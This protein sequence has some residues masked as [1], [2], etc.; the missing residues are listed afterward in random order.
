MK[1]L[2]L[3]KRKVS[4]QKRCNPIQNLLTFFISYSF[5]IY[6]K[7]S[8]H[9]KIDNLPLKTVLHSKFMFLQWEDNYNYLHG[10]FIL[11]SAQTKACA[12][13]MFRLAS[14]ENIGKHSFTMSS[15]PQTVFQRECYTLPVTHCPVLKAEM[16]CILR[17]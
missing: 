6:K 14:M 5:E 16:T 13:R 2:N 15:A 4:I 3:Q 7:N 11:F 17:H 9:S 1:V 12:T 8:I 10:V